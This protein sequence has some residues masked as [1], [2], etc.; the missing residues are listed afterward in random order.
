[1]RRIFAVLAVLSTF[2]CIAPAAASACTP[3]T[4]SKGTLS[5][6]QVGGNVAAS[7]DATGCQIGVYYDG[8]HGGEVNDGEIH[9]ASYFGVFVDGRA[10]D[11]EV[12]VTDSVIDDIG[13]TPFNGSQHGVGIYYYGYHTSGSVSGTVSGN[14][15]SQYQKGGI[16]VNGE[17]ASADVTDNTVTGLGPVGFIAQN[18]I[19]FG[20]G[21]TVGTVT[22]NSVSDN[23]YN[24]T[25]GTASAPD[26]VGSSVGVISTG[27]LFY[28]AANSPKKGAIAS[29]NH[30]FRNQGGITIVR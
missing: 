22:G 13:E 6:A 24:Q 14:D 2:A 29:S 21:A 7:L 30:V 23:I 10:G 17:E 19:Q 27:M 26:G 20:F 1:M 8:S 16:V 3:V 11:A 4:T 12:D 28:Q 25:G 9:G 18:G 5:A 15:V